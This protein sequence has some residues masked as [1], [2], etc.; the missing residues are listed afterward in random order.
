MAPPSKPDPLSDAAA[1]AHSGRR[2]PIEPLPAALGTLGV[3]RRWQVPIA[4]T[5][6]LAL[7]EGLYFQ[8][9]L[10]AVSVGLA[11]TTFVPLAVYGLVRLA[12]SLPLAIA[13]VFVL[14]VGTVVLSRF[15][16]P[17][18]AVGIAL[19]G[20]L[21]IASH[22]WQLK[23]RHLM[24]LLVVVAAGIRFG[25]AFG[26]SAV[27]VAAALAPSLV[28]VGLFQWYVRRQSYEREALV[29]VLELAARSQTPLGPAARAFAGLCGPQF[30]QRAATLSRR[31]E[32]GH[33][34]SDALQADPDVASGE[35][36]LFARIGGNWSALDRSLGDAV[37]S[38]KSR[39]H[40][41]VSLFSSVGYPLILLAVIAL[42]FYL[43]ATLLLPRIAAIARDFALAP[44]ELASLPLEWSQHLASLLP[45]GP[46]AFF[47][48]FTLAVIGA[49]V[50]GGLL[51]TILTI[52]GHP[53]PTPRVWLN[54]RRESAALMRGL[55]L[56]IE[57][58]RS[59]PEILRDLGRA[60]PSAWGRRR[61]RQAGKDITRGRHWTAA[62]ERRR[63]IGPSERA[64]LE[65]AE[66]ARNLPWAAREMGEVLERRATQRIR[67]VGILLQPVVLLALGALVMLAALTY[68]LPLVT[69][70]QRL[71]EEVQ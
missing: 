10:L 57:Q 25:M 33:P 38:T 60:A 68:F 26:A 27:V 61:V 2:T 65:A 63:L 13:S 3:L 6:L 28:L 34:L 30:Q 56:G 70:I 69:I 43:M 46:D 51:V 71:A 7:L 22:A 14:A 49:V 31:L 37:A 19:V 18:S 48:W 20:A 29:E 15:L 36:R 59:L 44:G 55:A 11:A 35:T 12:R 41:R 24:V 64:V 67:L 17:L 45:T 4:A 66:R 58:G 8:F 1:A 40:D 21:A 5:L 54:Q 47:V 52:Q 53:I 50:L 23:L 42:A 32:Q 39:R 9:G 62:L 16:D